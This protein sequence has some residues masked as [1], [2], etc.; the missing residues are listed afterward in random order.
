MEVNMAAKVLTEAEVKRVLAVIQSE[1]HAGRNRCAFMLSYL[2]GMR[3]VEICSLKISDVLDNEGKV[4]HEIRLAAEQTKGRKNRVV[5]VSDRLAK[6]IAAFVK[7]ND[8]SVPNGALIK[9]QKGKAFSPNTLV[10][11]FGRI[12]KLAGVDG[13]SSHSGRRSF[14][15]ELASKGVGAR[16]LQK[17]AGH[18]NRNTTQRYIEVNDK[19]LSEAVNLL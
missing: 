1:R 5:V 15:T 8:R 6:E 9:S 10:Q 4:K 18:Q 16:V 12:Y 3:A 19:M 17:L 2:A 7:N 13:A 14:I 11:L